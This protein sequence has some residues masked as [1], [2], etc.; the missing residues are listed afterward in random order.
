MFS[1][2]LLSW[3]IR[4]SILLAVGLLVA[5]WI[6]K[7]SATA[8]H[9]ILVVTCTGC[10]LIPVVMSL[11][12]AWQWHS[13][14]WLG[15]MSAPAEAEMDGSTDSET[16]LAFDNGP[17]MQFDFANPLPLNGR[18]PFDTANQVFSFTDLDAT[19]LSTQNADALM[20]ETPAAINFERQAAT[21]S[22]P[23]MN[24]IEWLGIAWL[25]ISIAL[26]LRVLFSLVVLRRHLINCKKA[27]TNVAN[28][29]KEVAIQLGVGMSADVRLA[30]ENAMPMSCWLG[31]P[32]IVLPSNFADWPAG[33]RNVTLA[34]E[35]GHVVRR[36]AWADYLVQVVACF[37]WLNP[38]VW[39]A[40]ADVRRLRERACDE[41]VLSRSGMSP[42]NYAE[43]LLAVVRCCHDQRL[44]LASPMAS[45]RD[46]ETRLAWLMSASDRRVMR[47][48][49]VAA[50]SFF[51]VMAGITIATGQLGQ[52]TSALIVLET[53]EDSQAT[54]AEDSSPAWPAIGVQGIVVDDAGKPL[55]DMNVVLRDLGQV[56]SGFGRV[57]DVLAKTKTDSEGRFDFYDAEFSPRMKEV[58]RRIC[59]GET[60]GQLLVWGPG[61]A[62][63]WE[64]ISSFGT[65]EKR[66]ELTDEA[67][68]TG[69]VFGP[70]G[71][72]IDGAKVQVSAFT[73]ATKDMS[74]LLSDPGDLNLFSSQFRLETVSKDGHFSMPNLPANSRVTVECNGPKAQRGYFLFDTGVGTFESIKYRRG[75]ERKVIR[76]PAR[77]TL[78]QKSSVQ[79]R[80]V[81]HAGNPVSGGFIEAISKDFSSGDGD[82]VG[83]DGMV[84]L[85]VNDAGRYRVTYQADPQSPAIGMSKQVDLQAAGSPLVE[86]KLT[87]P[88]FIEGRV[89][90]SESG[91]PVAGAS[92]SW[93][94]GNYNFDW[95]EKQSIGAVAVS[96]KNGVFR[97]P[98]VVGEQ[99]LQVGGEIDGYM[100]DGSG[101]G[102][103]V[104]VNEDG[105][106]EEVVIK[107]GFGLR[108]HGIVTDQ[109][110]QPIAGATVTA[111]RVR[112]D[113][114]KTSSLTDELGRYEIAGLPPHSKLRI[115][116]WSDAGTA[117]HFLDGNLNLSANKNKKKQVDLK[118]EAGTTLTGRVV[119]SGKP[120]SG[121]TVI[122]RNAPPQPPEQD[123]TRYYFLS[124]AVTD[125]DGRYR[126]TG[127]HKGEL[128]NLEVKAAG[129]AEVRDWVYSSPYIQE[130]KEEDGSLIELPD[131]VLSSNGQSLSGIVVDLE[132]RPVAGYTVN[133]SLVESVNGMSLSRPKNGPP[134]WTKT[135]KKGRFDLSYLPE[136]Q[137][138]LMTYK[139]NPEGGRID[140]PTV[141]EVTLNDKEIRIVVDPKL[142]GGIEDLDK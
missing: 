17:S 57:Q 53:A 23:K 73:K 67:E 129:D 38:L 128:Y 102:T 92:I 58:M 26:V 68:F 133:A 20:A 29:V 30:S 130:M 116:M 111:A 66:I 97:L 120:V 113:N 83:V 103:A 90:D 49:V 18:P 21:I 80:V 122:L 142:G 56:A 74:G 16:E 51:I 82:S 9:H 81:D 35:L 110:D 10:L 62:I 104:S 24:W 15:L 42:A 106:T 101:K 59:V 5:R 100:I 118:I 127:L 47:P 7:K 70:D 12:P 136:K 4:A 34:H 27:S 107:V 79:I 32:A 135:D 48:L 50:I 115:S 75:G 124:K 33:H 126:V 138:N 141:Q 114:R 60:G 131:A 105:S 125:A 37:L 85:I 71:Q 98:I 25:A 137:V 77:L 2:V 117:Q 84:T 139:A 31:G 65:Y 46:L 11:S 45:R 96:G 69:A 28:Y 44:K 64:L 8:A 112:G 76:S 52:P 86:F 91:D 19:K 123:W 63:V 132:G 134:P 140:Y 14:E 55:A 6:E 99:R 13:P 108:V 41:W 1:I 3:L 88:I 109:D 89:V 22:A 93:G 36:D 39:W 72:P 94:Y 119:Q 78:A 54:R 95:T 40:A 121:A 87:K 61:K 43:C